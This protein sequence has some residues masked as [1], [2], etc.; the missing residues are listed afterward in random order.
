MRCWGGN[1]SPPNP[2][3]PP[4]KGGVR[5]SRIDLRKPSRRQDARSGQP[6]WHPAQKPTAKKTP[7]RPSPQAERGKE[8]PMGAGAVASAWAR[9]LRAAGVAPGAETHREEDPTP[10]LPASGEGEGL[11]MVREPMRRCYRSRGLATGARRRLP[12][13]CAAV[14]PSRAPTKSSRGRAGR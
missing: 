8:L 2:L 11:P 14:R 7:R 3:S 1:P 10:A 12:M 6:A 9:P 5:G 4:G 13:L